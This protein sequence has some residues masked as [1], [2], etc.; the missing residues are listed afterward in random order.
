VG[1]SPCGWPEETATGSANVFVKVV[2][3]LWREEHRWGQKVPLGQMRNYCLKIAKQV[4][5]ELV[6]Q[7]A[8]GKISLVSMDG[9]TRLTAPALMRMFEPENQVGTPLLVTGGYRMT[10]SDTPGRDSPPSVLERQPPG[11]A[12]RREWAKKSSDCSMYVTHRMTDK[13]SSPPQFFGY[14]SEPLLYV[15]PALT[16]KLMTRPFKDDLDRSAP[17]GFWDLEGRRFRRYLGFL[18]DPENPAA[19]R[20]LGPSSHP[21]RR[22]HLYEFGR[23]IVP[24]S[25]DVDIKTMVS[26]MALLDIVRMMIRQPYHAARPHFSAGNIADVLMIQP[27]IARH[28]ANYFYA[29]NWISLLGIGPKRGKALAE[30]IYLYLT[31][32]KGFSL[33]DIIKWGEKQFRVKFGVELPALERFIQKNF[34]V[35]SE[36][37]S[38]KKLGKYLTIW[39]MA[40][41]EMLVLFYPE[42]SLLPG[43]MQEE[44]GQE[45]WRPMM[46]PEDYPDRAVEAGLADNEPD[47]HAQPAAASGPEVVDADSGRVSPISS[48]AM[49]HFLLSDRVDALRRL[50]ATIADK[51]VLLESDK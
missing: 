9:D 31:D 44:M 14:P 37:D 32:N 7:V 3:F 50:Q 10:T 2:P 47:S 26:R 29:G 49:A 45:R 21:E 42:K 24:F 39:A 35:D 23:F 30:I 18:V 40:V 8:P 27:A 51:L 5:D 11:T 16:E 13:K 20:V 41:Q 48:F 43:E 4:W 6:K 36:S 34:M 19:L 33:P 28:F 25:P 1:S 12:I 38:L 46:L 15:N 22:P 17:F